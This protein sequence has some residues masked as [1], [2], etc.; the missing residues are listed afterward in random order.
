MARPYDRR[1]WRRIREE[2]LHR[3]PLCRLHQEQGE[4]VEAR[5][6]DHIQPLAEG[7][8]FDDPQNL[9]SLCSACHGRVTRAW[10]SGQPEPTAKV[11]GVDAETGLPVGDHWWNISQ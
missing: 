9:R 6:V 3:E 2:Q 11:K 7:G 1:R 10:Q 5:E 4:I 8:A